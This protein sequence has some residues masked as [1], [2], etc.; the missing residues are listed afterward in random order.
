[1][2]VKMMT[3]PNAVTL[4]NL[5]CG[6]LGIVSMVSLPSGRALEVS[7]VL[8]VAAAVFDFLDGFVARLTRQYSEVGRQL[9]SL[10]DMVSFGVLPTLV[11]MKVYYLMGG[12]GAWGAVM[13][14]IA[15][16]AALRLA[17]FNVSDDQTTEF[18]G[19][20]T[21]ACALL[22]G[23]VGWTLARMLP[24]T[25]AGYTQWAVLAA[26]VVL[27]LLMVSRIRMFSLKFE[28]FGFRRNAVRYVFLLMA[29]IMVLILGMTGIGAAI[30][31]YILY[32]IIIW[33]FGRPM[34]R[35]HAARGEG[36]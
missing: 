16:C 30:L 5:L 23:S 28:G 1:M 21:P 15:A 19:L 24:V 9:D 36:R 10:A 3:L 14:L 29:L 4:A 18:E 12:Y 6:T 35:S 20:P 22:V 25:A 2:K 26:V 32:S 13:L 31:L 11:A 33:V 8:M 7:F 27:A 34:C 17:K